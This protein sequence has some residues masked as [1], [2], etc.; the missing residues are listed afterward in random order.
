MPAKLNRPKTLKTISDEDVEAGAKHYEDWHWGIQATKVIDG[1]DPDMPRMLIS[2]GNLIRLQFRTPRG[3]THPRRQKD[4]MLEL[5]KEASSKSY[6]AFDPEHPA[7]RLY[8]IIPKGV[9]D[10]LAKKMFKENKAQAQNLNV[11]ASIAGGN[12][13]RLQGYPDIM[14]KPLGVLTAVVYYTNKKGDGPS[15]YIHHIGEISTCFPILAV[16]ATGRLW[17]AGGNMTA[18]T[19]GITD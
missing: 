3:S 15:Y 11:L 12:H 8:L 13:G 14:A 6:I 19:P 10:W 5:S 1:M 4:P 9:R 17:I 18:P 2:C 7:Q 16:D